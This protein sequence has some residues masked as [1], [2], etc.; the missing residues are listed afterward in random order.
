M[1]SF[2][3]HLEESKTKILYHGTT[4]KILKSI[5][6]NGFNSP[7]YLCPDKKDFKQYFTEKYEDSFNTADGFVEIFMNPS[8]KELMEIVKLNGFDS[9]RY[10]INLDKKKIFVWDANILHDKVVPKLRSVLGTK[11]VHVAS[12]IIFYEKNSFLMS[13]FRFQTKMDA[14]EFFLGYYDKKI[15]WLDSTFDLQGVKAEFKTWRK[16]LKL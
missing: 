6:K 1:I 14:E 9:I 4:S 2:K 3:Q 11:L 8:K 10:A 16:R 13:N 7:V 5:K 12:G 15:G